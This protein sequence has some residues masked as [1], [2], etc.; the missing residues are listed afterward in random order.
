LREEPGVLNL[1]GQKLLK[2]A[3]RK[4]REAGTGLENNGLL[5]DERF[6]HAQGLA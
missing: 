5:W 2:A 4:K 3:D 6:Y 1:G